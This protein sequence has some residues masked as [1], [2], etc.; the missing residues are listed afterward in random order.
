MCRLFIGADPDQWDASTRS[1][2]LDG[3]VTSVRLERFF[4]AVLEDIGARD[5]L[6]LGQLLARLYAESLEEGRDI[7]N[8]ASFL[9]V[10]CGRYLDLQ[11][12]GDIPTDGGAPI[13]GL[14]AEGILA[15]ER[16][17]RDGRASVVPESGGASP[18]A[19]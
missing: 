18:V 12:T 9:R 6:S 4:W 5:G 19:N 3:Y 1:L 10:C 14:D 17:R 2:R 16:A 15:R 13:S 8:F 7:D 11:L